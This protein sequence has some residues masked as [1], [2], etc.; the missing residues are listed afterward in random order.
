MTITGIFSEFR[1]DYISVWDACVVDYKKWQWSPFELLVN[2]GY[3]Y[4]T[5]AI[6]E[7]ELLNNSSRLFPNMTDDDGPRPRPTSA[8][9]WREQFFAYY[10][11]LREVGRKQPKQCLSEW[12]NLDSLARR[13]IDV[14]SRHPKQED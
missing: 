10:R 6:D 2:N 7:E 9:E 3:Y 14:K 12:S 13:F 11:A 5:G 1:H 4:I 8:D